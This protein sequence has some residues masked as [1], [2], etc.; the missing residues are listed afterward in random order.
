MTIISNSRRFIFVHIPKCGGTSVTYHLTNLVQ[1]NDIEIGTTIFGKA[2][3]PAFRERFGLTK[4]S[5]AAAIRRVV[6]KEL[7]TSYTTFAVVRN[8]FARAVSTFRYLQRLAAHPHAPKHLK[9]AVGVLGSLDDFVCSDYWMT[10]GFDGMHRP[11]SYF[12]TDRKTGERLIVDRVLKLEAIADDCSAL[13]G[14]LGVEGLV[15]T[16]LPERNRAPEDSDELSL[17]GRVVEAIIARYRRD[18]EMFDYPL[19]VPQGL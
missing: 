4:H 2:L 8:P 16:R 12:V 18:F 19:S 13:N 7:W 6:G 15:D 10:E 9:P 14:L 17:S 11:Q 3:L 5:P 1:W